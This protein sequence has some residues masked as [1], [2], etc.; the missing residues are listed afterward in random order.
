LWPTPCCPCSG[1]SK[2]GFPL[3][4]PSPEQDPATET[5]V[6][7]TSV[8]A[9]RSG[10]NGQ[11]TVG[12]RHRPVVDGQRT[13]GNHQRIAVDCHRPVELLTVTVLS[14][15]FTDLPLMVNG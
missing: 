12:S 1:R 5:A 9:S 2:P 11:R 14:L 3:Q 13:V 10:G 15:V 4:Q 6:P 7:H 8:D